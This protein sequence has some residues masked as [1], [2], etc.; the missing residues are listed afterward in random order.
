ME[1]DG[2]HHSL[3]L[4][5]AAAKWRDE[6]KWRRQLDDEVVRQILET[7]DDDAL[8][9]NWPPLVKSATQDEQ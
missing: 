2:Q 7:S 5:E 9:G 4:I 8:A 3:A 6:Q 1:N